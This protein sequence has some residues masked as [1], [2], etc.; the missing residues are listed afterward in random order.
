[1]TTAQPSSLGP[2]AS[3]RKNGTPT[4]RSADNALGT[5]QTRSAGSVAGCAPGLVMLRESRDRI[6]SGN[7]PGVGTEALDCPPSGLWR[8][9][10]AHLTGGQGVAGSNPVSPT[11]S[12]NAAQLAW[13][14]RVCLAG[15]PGDPL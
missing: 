4:S 10:V 5:V 1:M 15:R 6:A 11:N 7:A 8:S 14:N 9:L 13:G 2:S 12:I 3:H